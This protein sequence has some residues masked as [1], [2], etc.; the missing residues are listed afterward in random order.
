MRPYIGGG[1]R[2][3]VTDAGANLSDLSASHRTGR[4]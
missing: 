2:V 4:L 1:I 3:P